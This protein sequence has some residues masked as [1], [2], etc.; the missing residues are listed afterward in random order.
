L[1]G[2][3]LDAAAA[4]GPAAG[5]A[6]VCGN[7]KTRRVCLR[8]ATSSDAAAGHPVAGEQLEVDT[9]HT[10]TLAPPWCMHCGCTEQ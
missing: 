3:W 2:G 5:A 6:G 8:S 7:R 10:H 4:A 1:A 9:L